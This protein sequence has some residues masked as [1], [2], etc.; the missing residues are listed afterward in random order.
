[1]VSGVPAGLAAALSTAALSGT[2]FTTAATAT[3]AIAMTTLQKT[4][5]AV[6]LTAVV[7]VGIYEA[8]Q[9][10]TLRSQNQLFQQ[11]QALLADQIQQLTK[12]RDDATRRLA[13]L[14]DDNERLK[15][16]TAELPRLRGKIGLLQQALASRP[17]PQN[18]NANWKPGT[19]RR[20][21][22]M[23]DVGQATPEAALQ[24]IIWAA[25]MNPQRLMDMVHLPA[26]GSTDPERLE[27][28][29]QGMAN[30]YTN[31]DWALIK[32]VT[33][34]RSDYSKHKHFDL[35]KDKDGN[36]HQHA[37]DFDEYVEVHID[38]PGREE[39]AAA[40][41]KLREGDQEIPHTDLL[42]TR[43]RF[44]R[45]G[46]EWRQVIPGASPDNLTK[47]ADVPRK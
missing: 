41:E 7:G 12:D 25:L 47:S 20:L 11:Q 1:V 14:S 15:R 26:P 19:S 13:A 10:S 31:V 5:I 24:T 22:E 23:S 42:P 3:Q 29:R 46:N 32:E 35:I 4:V 6:A 16:N 37:G 18:A 40:L 17:Q 8:R 45:V 43:W 30:T 38:Y 34:E 44:T 2:T 33:I 28:M 36:I 9:A 27:Q 39:A 21:E